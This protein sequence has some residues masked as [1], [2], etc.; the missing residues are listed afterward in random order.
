MNHGIPNNS[1]IFFNNAH[2]LQ[3][4]LV[5]ITKGYSV[6]VYLMCYELVLK[7]IFKKFNPILPKLWIMF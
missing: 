4:N 2:S 1:L 6:Y 5:F 3:N 7:L